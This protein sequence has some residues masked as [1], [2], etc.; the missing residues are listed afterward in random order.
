[1]LADERVYKKLKCAPTI[2]QKET[3]VAL[4]TGMKDQGRISLDQ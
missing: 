4:L 1:M 3:V 2:G